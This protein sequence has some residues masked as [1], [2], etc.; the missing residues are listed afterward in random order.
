MRGSLLTGTDRSWTVG[1]HVVGGT[2]GRVVE[3]TLWIVVL[4]LLALDVSTTW[5]GLTMGLTEGNPMMR[6]AI[7]S[8]GVAA[9]AAVKLAVVGGAVCFRAARPRHG[10]VIALGL[11]LPWAATV[12]VNAIVLATV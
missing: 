6:W 5:V 8:Y 4:A 7:D 11:A 10:P 9:L 1:D 12:S 3:R 2:G